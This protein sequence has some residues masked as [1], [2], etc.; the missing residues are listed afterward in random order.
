MQVINSNIMSLNAQRNLSTSGSQLATSL[1]RL[2]SGLRINSAKDDAAGL[3]ISERFTTQ[4]RGMDQAARNANDG[5]SL[6]QT[7]EGAMGEIGNNLQRIRELAVQ[8]RNATN[9]STDRAALNAEAQQLKSEIDRVAEQTSF[10]GTKLLDG[11]FTDQAFQ[12]GANQGET[13]TVSGITNASSSA[14][15]TWTSAPTTT[16]SQTTSAA[17][18]TAFATGMSI[19]VNG[20]T[21]STAAGAAD[22]AAAATA[23]KAAFDTAKAN[24][25]NTALANVTM[26]AA[27]AITSTDKTLTLANA[28]NVSGVTA[29]ATNGTATTVAGTA[30]TGFGALDIST[31]DGA[32]AAMLAMDGAL[33]AI[34]TAR[35]NMGAVQNRFSSV[36]AN[37]G[38]T[39]ENLSA[40]RSRIQDADFAAETAK[41]TRNQILQ[42]AGT[43]MLAQA[44][45]APQGVLSLLR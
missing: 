34:N 16:Y 14:L 43:A 30:Q 41:L 3:A 39:S 31:V 27:G 23:F 7:A 42:Q 25:A 1:Q 17:T 33:T 15:G 35:A 4:V 32:D 45:Q 18:A 28:A 36:V 13:I 21:I 10:N 40:A 2:S 37:L 8:S 12:V 5:I 9:S 22:A 20:V 24:P 26:S 44:N 6:S 29:G 19:D 38:S 11:S